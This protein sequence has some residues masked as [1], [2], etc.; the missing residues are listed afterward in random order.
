MPTDDEVF[1]QAR[2]EHV[3]DVNK[4]GEMSADEVEY[5]DRLNEL[6]DPETDGLECE[7]G[8]TEEADGG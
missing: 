4:L 6:P 7:H 5:L 2:A 1:A 3:E 8:M